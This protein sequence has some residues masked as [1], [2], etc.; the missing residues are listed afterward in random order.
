MSLSD[1]LGTAKKLENAIFLPKLDAYLDSLNEKEWEDKTSRKHDTGLHP[2]QISGCLRRAIFSKLGAEIIT[3]P[4][5]KPLRVH[6]KSR[7]IF[8]NGSYL[9]ERMQK[10]FKDMGLLLGTWECKSCGSVSPTRQIEEDLFENEGLTYKEEGWVFYN[11]YKLYDIFKAMVPVP[12]SCPYCGGTHFTYAEVPIYVPE[13]EVEGRTDGIAYLGKDYLKDIRNRNFED[14]Y[15]LEFKSEN[16]F[17]FQKHSSAH[18]VHINQAAIYSFGTGFLVDKIA[19]IYEDKNTQEIK[20]YI[21]QV[22]K[23][24]QEEVLRRIK[25]LNHSLRTKELPK[26]KMKSE[27]TYCPHKIVCDSELTYEQIENRVLNIR[28]GKEISDENFDLGGDMLW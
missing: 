17:K 3:T 11:K 7:R 1:I 9:H 23:E 14:F 16:S 27:C 13:Q 19:V 10:Y 5:R 18:Q 12:K 22:T 2:S 26:D 25:I 24:M 20:E 4:D 15:I 8:D 6:P 21:V 28:L